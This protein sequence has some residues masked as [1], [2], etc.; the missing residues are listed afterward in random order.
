VPRW[1]DTLLGRTRPT[2]S[3]LDALFRL[4]GAAVTLQAVMGLRSTGE[5]AVSYKPASGQGFNAT[6]DE[7]TELVRFGAQQSESEVCITDDTFGYRWVVLSDPDLEDLV[8]TIHLANSTL[9]D[10]GFGTQLLCSV[11]AFADDSGARPCHLVYLYKRGTFYPFAPRDGQRRDNELELQ[12]RSTLV[13]ELPIEP[14]LSRWFA[15]W[16]LPLS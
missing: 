12:V 6:G 10:R 13:D 3:N 14:D 1:L 7:L 4:T 11:F 15:L 16:G 5:A 2:Q 9:E 8:T